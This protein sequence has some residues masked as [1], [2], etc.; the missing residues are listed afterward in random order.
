[1]AMAHTSDER[2]VDG[3]VVDLST[4]P[5]AP[6]V[7]EK[8]GMSFVFLDPHTFRAT[9][10]VVSATLSIDATFRTNRKPQETIYASPLVV[11]NS[12]ITTSY[13][14]AEEGTYDMHLSFVDTQG[15]TH[16]AGFRKQ[17]RSGSTE[18]TPTV[19]PALFFLTIFIVG[20]FCFVA[21]RL[22]KKPAS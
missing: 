8:M 16:E 7:G 15:K 11:E 12:G 10:T 4:A 5:V 20:A 18:G 14:F 17:V 3:Y 19:T 21:G 9:T 22:W 1:M 13:T 6:W 2:Y